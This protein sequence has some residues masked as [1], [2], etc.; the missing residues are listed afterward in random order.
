[1]PA[2]PSATLIRIAQVVAIVGLARP[3][4]YKLMQQ[5]E[6]GFPLPVKLSDSN[7]R[8]APVAWVLSEVQDW[9]RARIAARRRDAA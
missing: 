8:G 2:D 6:S 9:V 4:I 1:M 7:A 5:K 3:T